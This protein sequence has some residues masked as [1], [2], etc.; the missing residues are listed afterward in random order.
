MK[1]FAFVFLF[2]LFALPIFAQA[3]TVQ[4]LNAIQIKNESYYKPFPVEPG[5]YFDLYL[6]I[7][8]TGKGAVSVD[9]RLD[10]S[11]PFEIDASDN[12][13]RVFYDFQADREALLKYHIRVA[14]NAVEG[15]NDLALSCASL[16]GGPSA[17]ATFTISVQARASTVNIPSVVVSPSELQPGQNGRITVSVKSES[18]NYLRDFKIKLDT[19]SD[20]FP[21]VVVNGTNERLLSQVEPHQDMAFAFDVFAYPSAQPGAYKLP[22]S[23]TYSDKLGKSY[24]ISQQTGIRVSTPPKLSLGAES[25]DI[26][27]AGST[28][29]VLLRVMNLG[30]SNVKLLQVKLLPSNDYVVLSSPVQYVGS[31]NSDDFETAEFKV[32]VS[33]NATG[34]VV[35]NAVLEYAD[36]SNSQFSQA[37][38]A[39]IRLFTPAEAQRY[40]LASVQDNSIL[41][42][43]LGLV[44]L[45]VLV[46]YVVP[47]VGRFVGQLGRKKER[48]A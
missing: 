32:H 24:S 8:N 23:I 15:N 9:C 7:R 46:K 11:Y 29:K 36:S 10:P 39:S 31:V 19:S 21:F 18:P 30:L 13:S 16:D 20:S 47:A 3:G 4:Y 33:E 45:F 2:A 42:I 35:F 44:G 41:N 5:S 27:A 6:S 34:E 1:R 43:I 14:D 22:I 37:G 48:G 12:P 26:S 25:A 38:S 28:G 17:S 40:G